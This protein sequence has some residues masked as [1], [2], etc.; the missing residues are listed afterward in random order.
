MVFYK[1]PSMFIAC[2]LSALSHG[3]CLLSLHRAE[4]T[5]H[6]TPGNGDAVWH[7]GWP[8]LSTGQGTRQNLCSLLSTILQRNGKEQD[9]AHLS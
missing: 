6:T 1:P 5:G 8:L 9:A 3:K 4:Q 2:L 7:Y